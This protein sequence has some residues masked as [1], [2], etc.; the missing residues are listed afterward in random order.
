MSAL[1]ECGGRFE[2]VLPVLIGTGARTG[3]QRRNTEN[4]EL[5]DKGTGSDGFSG[6]SLRA[7][8]RLWPRSRKLV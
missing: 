6:S 2:P 1:I 5:F 4:P 3:F 7:P 8:T